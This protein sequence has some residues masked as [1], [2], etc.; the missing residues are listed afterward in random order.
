[1][2]EEKKEFQKAEVVVIRFEKTDI[3]TTSTC[4]CNGV[5]TVTVGG[6]PAQGDNP[7]DD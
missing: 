7:F 3:I 5:F 4:T 1:M 2:K 6:E